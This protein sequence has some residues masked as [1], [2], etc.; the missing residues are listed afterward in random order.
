MYKQEDDRE[1]VLQEPTEK[2]RLIGR[3]KP[4]ECE[5]HKSMHLETPPK[6]PMNADHSHFSGTYRGWVCTTCNTGL[7]P[8]IDRL[9]NSGVDKSRIKA[10]LCF[11]VEYC[12]SEGRILEDLLNVGWL[13]VVRSL[14]EA[15]LAE[16]ANPPSGLE[17]SSPQIVRGDKSI[18]EERIRTEFGGGKRKFL[19]K[20]GACLS[21]NCE[22]PCSICPFRNEVIDP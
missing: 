8:E 19:V 15:R 18:Y 20:K 13:G 5:L 6:Q 3:Y 12:I 7:L 22:N 10:F 14:K 21:T 4:E 2:E 11:L 1:P 9:L 16:E 17:E